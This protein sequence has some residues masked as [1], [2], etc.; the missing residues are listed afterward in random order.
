MS[1][2]YNDEADAGH[3]ALAPP[4]QIG[5]STPSYLLYG[6]SVARRMRM[7]R[8]DR[9]TMWSFLCLGTV[10]VLTSSLSLAE[11]LH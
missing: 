11:S 10:M 7:V 6:E 3:R 1:L 9:I 2:Q 8:D 4:F 5:E